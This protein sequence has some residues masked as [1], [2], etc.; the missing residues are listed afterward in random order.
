MS[1]GRT[2]RL[3]QN[4]LALSDDAFNAVP[5]LETALADA[6]NRH[7]DVH[8]VSTG[9]VMTARFAPRNDAPGAAL[10]VS[11]GTFFE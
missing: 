1:D 5:A 2:S 6:L 3:T 7:I 10:H 4:F 11:R 9:T 8:H